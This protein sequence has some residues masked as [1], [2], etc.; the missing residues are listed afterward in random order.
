MESLKVLSLE[1]KKMRF[2]NVLFL[3][4]MSYLQ[5]CMEILFELDDL[6]LYEIE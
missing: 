6:E 3:S 1:L 5:K 4:N 2:T